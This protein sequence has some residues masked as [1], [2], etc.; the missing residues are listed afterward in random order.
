VANVALVKSRD[1]YEAVTKALNLIR[2]DIRLPDKP[3]LIKPNLVVA[4]K[5]QGAISVTHV[6]AT[7]ATMDFLKGL[8]VKK[9]IVGDG[10]GQGAPLGP[11]LDNFGYRQLAK[12]YDVEF[13]DLNVDPPVEVT[14]FD[15]GLR[16]KTFQISKTVVDCYRVSVSRM[17]THDTVVVTL[18]I[19]NT[20]IGCLLGGDNKR[21][22]HDG[23]PAINLS[24]AKLASFVPNDIS[25]IDG[26]EGME[27]DGPV[28]GTVISSGMALASVDQLACDTIGA[29][30]MGFDPDNV[31]YLWYLK[32]M[33]GLSRR[34]IRVLGDK[35]EACKTTFKPHSKYQEQLN[36]RT[37]SWQ[38]LLPKAA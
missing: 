4:R 24:M 32:Q 12:R 25:I 26:V 8:G 21:A 16:P 35:P 17:K 18:A 30:L 15:A 2:G 27:G 31:G 36:W 10:A 3:I 13:R 6:D 37:P 22:I 1:R 23:Y 28:D 34:A 38:G 29:E 9:F 5:P 14:L 7:I 20:V 11:V 19:K 33:Q